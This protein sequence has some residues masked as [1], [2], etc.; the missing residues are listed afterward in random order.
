MGTPTQP[1][2]KHN[3]LIPLHCHPLPVHTLTAMD[4]SVLTTGAGELP[5]FLGLSLMVILAFLP[6]GGAASTAV[7]GS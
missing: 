4:A 6:G 3:P 5:H 1:L 7:D 2:V